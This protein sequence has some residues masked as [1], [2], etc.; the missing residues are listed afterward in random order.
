M[1]GSK[2]AG[3]YRE[4]YCYNCNSSVDI[5]VI[6]KKPKDMDNSIIFELI[7]KNNNNLKIIVLDDEFHEC[8]NCGAELK[9]SPL[10]GSFAFENDNFYI[11]DVFVKYYGVGK[12]YDFWGFHY[13]FN[14]PVCKEKFNKFVIRQNNKVLDENS[15]KRIINDNLHELNLFKFDEEKFC[16]KC[17]DKIYMIESESVCPNC[18]K[19]KLFVKNRA[20]ID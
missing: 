7:E 10:F 19:G 13:N 4:Y 3:H 18:R 17:N 1:D 15:I 9:S 11:D 2:I 6:R 12:N 14:C 5:F 20:I 16:P 8:V